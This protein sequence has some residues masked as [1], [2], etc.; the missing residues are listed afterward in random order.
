MN[1]Q[2]PARAPMK[3][4]HARDF[5]DNGYCVRVQRSDSTP[6]PRYS[7]SMG[8]V[9]PDGRF[10]P[11]VGI[12]VQT[13]RGKVTITPIDAVFAR[14]LAE[15]QSWIEGLCQEKEDELRIER[16]EKEANRG[17]PVTRRTGK[18]ERDRAKH[19]RA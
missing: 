18:T 11:F 14:L 1:D 10:I 7:L 16:E 8:R 9:P 12:F 6:R 5:T 13:E 4:S 19:V 17:K 15:A 3:W 2:A